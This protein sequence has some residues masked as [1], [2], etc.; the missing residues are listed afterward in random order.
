M[1]W[2]WHISGGPGRHVIKPPLFQFTLTVELTRWCLASY[3]L[4]RMCFV[5]RGRASGCSL[6]VNQGRWAQQINSGKIMTNTT[7]RALVTQGRYFMLLIT[8]KVNIWREFPNHLT[9]LH[10][11]SLLRQRQALWRRDVADISLCWCKRSSA[12]FPPNGARLL[13]IWTLMFFN[14]VTQKF[15]VLQPLTFKNILRHRKQQIN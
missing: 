14:L 1:I 11:H 10:L 8:I 9:Y 2:P 6:L 7:T 4:C 13:V 12:T 5:F 3:L 15:S